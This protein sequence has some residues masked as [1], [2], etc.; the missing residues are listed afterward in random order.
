MTDK[1]DVVTSLN[2]ISDNLVARAKKYVLANSLFSLQALAQIKSILD[3]I[4]ITVLCKKPVS[5]MFFAQM[6]PYSDNS[7]SIS[8]V[9]D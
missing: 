1:D 9:Y 4:I 5:A 6:Y 7:E 3:R 2:K 8:S